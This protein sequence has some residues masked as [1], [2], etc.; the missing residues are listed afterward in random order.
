ML[1]ARTISVAVG[2]CFIVLIVRS[3]AL[4]IF[5]IYRLKATGIAFS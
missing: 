1:Y 2:L 3:V 4:A 5:Q